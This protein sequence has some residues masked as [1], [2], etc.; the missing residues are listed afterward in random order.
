MVLL[1]VRKVVVMVIRRVMVLGV[2][3][4]MVVLMRRVAVL[5]GIVGDDG[6]DEDREGGE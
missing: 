2:V 5:E 1:M 4:V 3:F 6:G